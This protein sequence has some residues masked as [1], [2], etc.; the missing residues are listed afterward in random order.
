MNTEIKITLKNGCELSTYTT[1]G[2]IHDAALKIMKQC[3]Q[4]IPSEAPYDNIIISGDSPVLQE[5]TNVFKKN[6][7]LNFDLVTYIGDG[8]DWNYDLI[9]VEELNFNSVKQ[10]LLNG[11]L[12]LEEIDQDEYSS[13]F[14]PSWTKSIYD[15]DFK[16]KR[17][18]AIFLRYCELFLDSKILFGVQTK[19]ITSIEIKLS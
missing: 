16:S 10:N 13:A 2:S 9:K 1:K 8:E 19:N 18:I 14:L 5:I 15:A 7:S 17:N 11:K 12:T 3:V 6:V 4:C